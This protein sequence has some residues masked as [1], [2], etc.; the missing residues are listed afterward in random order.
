[1]TRPNWFLNFHSSCFEENKRGDMFP[2]INPRTD[3][4]QWRTQKQFSRNMCKVTQSWLFCYKW[5]AH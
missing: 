3:I 5:E 4:Y 1:L 2:F